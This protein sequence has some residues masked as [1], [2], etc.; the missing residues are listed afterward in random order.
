MLDRKFRPA[1]WISRLKTSRQELQ[2]AKERPTKGRK[3]RVNSLSWVFL[4]L[5]GVL[6]AGPSAVRSS[7]AH[8]F[9]GGGI[10]RRASVSG[11]ARHGH[12]EPLG[13]PQLPALSFCPALEEEH[14]CERG[15]MEIRG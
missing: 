10:E 14:A 11:W 6:E 15:R 3:R 13:Q 9:L 12:G 2:K 4:V 5:L 1:E 7:Q 8:V